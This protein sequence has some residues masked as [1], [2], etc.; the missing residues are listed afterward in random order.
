MT[1][2][3]ERAA[4]AMC[5]SFDMDPDELECASELTRALLLALLRAVQA[6]QNKETT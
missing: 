5:L 6:E 2:A 4:R 1:D 3:L